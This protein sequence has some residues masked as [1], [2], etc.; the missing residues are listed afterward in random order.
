MTL[1]AL[2]FAHSVETWRDGRLVGGLYGVS[3]GA[4]F[5]GESMFHRVSNASKIALHALVK[6]LRDG[7]FVLLDTQWRT[8]HLDQFGAREIPRD[9]YLSVL[10]DAVRRDARFGKTFSLSPFLAR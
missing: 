1:H 3:I 6:I 5:F 2:G 7:G 10:A 4:A 9:V 8:P